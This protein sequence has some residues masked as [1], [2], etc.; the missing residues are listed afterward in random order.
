MI[1]VEKNGAENIRS[2]MSQKA[3]FSSGGDT[4]H[5]RF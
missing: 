1:E 4:F 2:G 3:H 5:S